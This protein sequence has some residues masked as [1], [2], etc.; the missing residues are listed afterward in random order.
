M[1]RGTIA[2]GSTRSLGAS[3][4]LQDGRPGEFLHFLHE[5]S[6]I[7]SRREQR[8]SAGL[9]TTGPCEVARRPGRC[10]RR[11]RSRRRAASGAGSWSS[12]SGVGDRSLPLIENMLAADAATATITISAH[13]RTCRAATTRL[14]ICPSAESSHEWRRTRQRAGQDS[15]K[16]MDLRGGGGATATV[17][18]EPNGMGGETGRSGLGPGRIERRSGQVRFGSRRGR[19][20]GAQVWGG[21]RRRGE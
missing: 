15:E 9:G 6:V 5:V 7:P 8:G 11:P 10:G 21:R 14:A 19:Q 20:R 17:G 13:R 18:S 4:H 3:V 2:P 12:W 16:R 1:A